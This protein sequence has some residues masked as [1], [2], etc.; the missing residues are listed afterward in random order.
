MNDAAGL[1]ARC[2]HARKLSTKSGAR[3]YLCGRSKTD[4]RFAKY[5]RLP[6]AEC[7]GYEPAPSGHSK[8]PRF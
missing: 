1:C 7:P 2:L 6:M 8:F 5:P 4:A 3:I